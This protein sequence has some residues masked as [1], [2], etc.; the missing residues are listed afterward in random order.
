MNSPLNKPS[1]AI[2]NDLDQLAHDTATLL[3]AT[4]DM[5]DERIG[6]ARRRLS[7]M[8]GRGR[9]L[10]DRVRDKAFQGTKAADCAMHRNLYQSIAIGVGAGVVLGILLATRKRCVCVH[11]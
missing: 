11:E 10:C 6:D 7:S 1:Q 4:A 3:A 9:E 5:A 8:L 2:E